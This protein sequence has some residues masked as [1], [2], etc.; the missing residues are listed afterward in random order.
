MQGKLESFH[1][2]Q[3]EGRLGVKRAKTR[4][5][6]YAVADKEGLKKKA[7]NSKKSLQG[8]GDVGG[9]C[10]RLQATSI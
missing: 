2:S 5:G 9:R 4:D 10:T 3:K 8:G 6:N 7:E 1:Q